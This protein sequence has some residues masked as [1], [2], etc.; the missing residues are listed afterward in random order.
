M[1]QETSTENLNQLELMRDEAI[2]TSILENLN[3]G[4]ALID[5]E[6]RF[7]AYNKKFLNLFGLS[8]E[9]TISNVNDQNWADWQVYGE[10]L[11]LLHVNDHPVRK[12]AL[13]G[14]PVKNQLVGVRLPSGNNIIWMLVSAQPLFDRKGN[15]DKTICTYL[16]VTEH[17][18]ADAALRRSEQRYRQLFNSMSEILQVLELIHDAKGNVIDYIYRD[19]NPAFEQ[20]TGMEREQLLNKRV[21]EVFGNINMQWLEIFGNVYE[22]GVPVRFE[23]YGHIFK[24]YYELFVWKTVEDKIAV[25]FTDI[26]ERKADEQA[27]LESENR[28]KELNAT[29]DKLFSIISHDLKSP[30]SGII[31]FSE[32]LLRKLKE[33]ETGSAQEYAAIILDSSWQAMDLLNNLIEWS[34]LQTGRM[35]FNPE[36]LDIIA[37]IHEVK[38]LL[39]ATSNHKSVDISVSLSDAPANLRVMADRAMISSVLRNL[40]SNAIKFSYQGGR[41]FINVSKMNEEIVVGVR[42]EGTGMDKE[43]SGKILASESFA[44]KRGTKNESGTGLGLVIAREFISKHGGEMCVES[45]P[46]KGSTFVFTL[47]AE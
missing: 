36:S 26:T 43:T 20:L 30:F 8:E 16:D 28:L 34:R 21:T 32:L 27:L 31:G 19:V 40:I 35:S 5:K 7:T 39:Y 23:S 37:L 46:G 38:D 41:I 14:K 13:T 44:T 3:S 15:I 9:S 42:D 12:A 45:E 6:G 22:S 29:K 1:K 2:L 47:P 18:L 10:D 33:D 11:K 25:I 24:K 4:V 17:K